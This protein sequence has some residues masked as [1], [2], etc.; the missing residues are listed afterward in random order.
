MKSILRHKF[1]I[2]SREFG[3]AFT[4]VHLHKSL[5]KSLEDPG[6]GMV[7]GLGVQAAAH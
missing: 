1:Q 6:Q 7:Q 4:G 5:N 3:L 2:I